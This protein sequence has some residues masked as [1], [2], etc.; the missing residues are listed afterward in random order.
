MVILQR[1]VR[2]WENRNQRT[3]SHSSQNS[4]LATTG[5]LAKMQED[6]PVDVCIITQVLVS[7]QLRTTPGEGDCP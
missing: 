5:L 7:S 4:V 1:A 3:A 6:R 2:P